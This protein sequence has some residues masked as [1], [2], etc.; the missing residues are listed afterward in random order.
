MSKQLTISA[1][2][3]VFAMAAFV[4]FATPS[5]LRLNETGAPT[6]VAAPAFQVS[7]PGFLEAQQQPSS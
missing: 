6:A 4:M 3:S 1:A 2:F 7:L 5:A